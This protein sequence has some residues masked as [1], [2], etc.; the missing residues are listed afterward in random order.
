MKRYYLI[1][2]AIFLAIGS[3]A[4]AQGLKSNDFE[5][6]SGSVK[7]NIFSESSLQKENPVKEF[8]TWNYS[9]K[10]YQFEDAVII[11]AS[12]ENREDAEINDANYSPEKQKEEVPAEETNQ[13]KI[14]I[15]PNPAYDHINVYVNYPEVSDVEIILFNSIGNPIY[16]AKLPE[17]KQVSTII[18]VSSYNRGIYF[19]EIKAG[20]K[21]TI[22]RIVIK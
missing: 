9:R 7:F 3:I 20:G 6:W 14:N 16:S 8:E 22:K 12:D 11:P 15:Y 17:K 19:L 5:I 4:F 10:F 1:C 21:K 2:L 18:E 13:V